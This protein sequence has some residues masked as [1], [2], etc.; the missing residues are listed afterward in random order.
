MPVNGSVSVEAE[1]FVPVNLEKG[2]LYVATG[3]SYVKEAEISARSFKTHMPEL[4][5]ALF[6]DHDGAATK[7]PFDII[8]R[9]PDPQYDFRDRILALKDTPFSKSLHLDTDTFCV[10]PCREV[11]ELLAH[12]DFAAAHAPRRYGWPGTACPPSFPE[13]NVGV[14]VYGAGD[15]FRNVLDEWCRRYQYLRRLENP[16]RHDQPAFREAVYYSR[17]RF[18]VLTPEYNLRTCFPYFIGGCA[19]VKIIHDRGDSLKRALAIVTAQPQ[20]AHRFPRVVRP[21]EV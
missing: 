15:I 2:I 11:F 14:I 20:I 8:Q 9:L 17:A 1:R 13:F 19:R 12:F 6:T 7:G 3:R 16:P 5:I 18:T 10:G 21:I 4:P